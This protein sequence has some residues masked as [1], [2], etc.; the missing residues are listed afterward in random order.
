MGRTTHRN[1]GDAKVFLVFKGLTKSVQ[2]VLNKISLLSLWASDQVL[3]D[4]AVLS[5][6]NL[7]HLYFGFTSNKIEYL[8]AEPY[9]VL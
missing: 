8:L 1:S 5:W 9:E 3:R 7:I 6:T 4:L 2:E